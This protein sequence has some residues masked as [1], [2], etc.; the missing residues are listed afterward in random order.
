MK[1]DTTNILH[2]VSEHIRELACSGGNG[3]KISANQPASATNTHA[4]ERPKSIEKER[5][6]RKYTY[7]FLS[8]S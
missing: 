4:Y 5:N 1:Q 7:L 2:A 3:E 8:F 6:N